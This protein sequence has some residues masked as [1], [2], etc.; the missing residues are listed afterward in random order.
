MS[1]SNLDDSMKKDVFNLANE[2]I[3]E[4]EDEEEAQGSKNIN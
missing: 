3:A 2:V 1:S 4:Q